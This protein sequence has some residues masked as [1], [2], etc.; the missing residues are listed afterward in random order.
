VS[1]AK[2][3]TESERRL[4]QWASCAFLGRC[5][6]L[7]DLSRRWAW[8]KVRDGVRED[9]VILYDECLTVY[10]TCS[11][12]DGLCAL[13]LSSQKWAHSGQA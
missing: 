8:R 4:R 9:G 3:L 2:L 13:S 11:W 1:F 7:E 5:R 6:R 12:G 10:S